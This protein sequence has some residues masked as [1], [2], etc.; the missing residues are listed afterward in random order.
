MIKQIIAALFILITTLS[1]GQPIKEHKVTINGKVM[2]A[3]VIGGDTL[4]LAELDDVSVTSPREF[5]SVDEYQK[6]MRYRRYANNV[7]PY[8][9]EAIKIFRQVEYETS[10]LNRR[11]Q[12]KHNKQL[13]KE[14]KEEFS[15]PLK[16]LSRT[17]GYILTKMI[18]RELDKP[19]FELIKGLRGGFTAGYWNQFG[20]FYGYQL[21]DKYEEGIDPILDAVLQDF[22]ISYDLSK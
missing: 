8:A 11:Q 2:S 17:Q 5:G 1:Y 10:T 6:Y 19:M 22:D 14:L 7:Y 12:K 15:D 13:Q 4:I 20:K 9:V 16:Q 18:E 3:M 21:K